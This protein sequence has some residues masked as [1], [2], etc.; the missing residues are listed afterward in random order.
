M[1]W[2]PIE[3]APRDGTQVDIWLVDECGSGWRETD[4]FFVKNM[5]D[6]FSDYSS[7]AHRFSKEI[8]DG[9][10]ASGHDHDG[11]LGF[12]DQP[13]RY[14]GRPLKPTWKKPTHWMPIPKP[15]V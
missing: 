8:R 5:S 12:C 14:Y 4:A 1:D 6:E 3:T 10:I 13:V 11:G 7:G 15:P 9:W 2:M